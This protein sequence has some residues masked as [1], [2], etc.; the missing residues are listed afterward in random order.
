M[1]QRDAGREGAPA[2]RVGISLSGWLR[3]SVRIK[4]KG[5]EDWT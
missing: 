5:S 1:G 3:R 4:G 2:E